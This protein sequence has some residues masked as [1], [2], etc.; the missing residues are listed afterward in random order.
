MHG[1]DGGGRTHTVSL[2]L[3]FESSASANSATSAQ[4]HGNIEIAPVE[5]NQIIRLPAPWA[6]QES[7]TQSPP[8]APCSDGETARSF[9]LIRSRVSA[10]A[11]SEL[12]PDDVRSPAPLASKIETHFRGDNWRVER[13]SWTPSAK[14]I[15]PQPACPLPRYSVRPEPEE[16]LWRRAARAGQAGPMQLVV[17]HERLP[18]GWAGALRSA[19]G[20][21][22]PRRPASAA[23]VPP[24]H[25]SPR[26]EAPRQAEPASSMGA[27]PSRSA[28]I[29][30]RPAESRRPLAGPSSSANPKGQ[31]R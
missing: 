2:P 23:I 25:W 12:C 11:P 7:S 27:A 24:N 30:I 19:A 3:D 22:A 31:K 28:A 18:A 1:A 10:G 16:L 29:P 8:D 6:D 21:R 5:V 13:Q 17:L 9:A 14:A 15:G 20:R 4:R 26:A